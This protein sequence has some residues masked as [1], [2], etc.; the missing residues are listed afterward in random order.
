MSLI[1]L[2]GS[3]VLQ[4]GGG[5]SP[6]VVNSSGKTSTLVKG[7]NGAHELARRLA[8]LE[9]TNLF[10]RSYNQ[11]LT[12]AI[13]TG[14]EL[15]SA[16]KTIPPRRMTFPDT[17]IGSQLGKCADLIAARKSFQTTRQIF[18]CEVLGY[19]THKQQRDAH[20]GLLS[21]LDAAIGAFQGE[22]DAAGLSNSVTLFTAS[23]F[24]RTANS[25]ED[26]SDHGWGGHQ[27]II[28][29]AV[30]GGV[31]GTIPSLRDE[32]PQALNR[33][34]LIPSFSID[35]FVAPLA[36]WFGVPDGELSD[37][38]PNLSRFDRGALPFL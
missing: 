11:L 5:F 13:E 19:D 6:F 23:E 18:F 35:Q 37:I 30:K 17:K 28:G 15:S 27:F 8:V 16:L 32:S 36:R 26:G 14:D 25:S 31:Y 22:I 24:G 3:N 21:D 33:G 9:R 7:P 29:G 1:S 34:R 20:A 2:A 38:L 12:R 10:E 4:S